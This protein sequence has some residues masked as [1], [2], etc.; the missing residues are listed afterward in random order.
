MS[1]RT[2]FRDS[3]VAAEYPDRPIRFIVPFAAGGPG[4]MLARILAER[5]TAIWGQPVEIVIRH[6]ANGIAGS[7]MTARAEADGYTIAISASAFY[8]N[9]SIYRELPFDSIADFAPVALVAGGPN[10]LVTHP[11]V[12]AR[13][14]SEFIAHARA[15]PGALAYASGGYGS[16]SHLAGELFN[17][18]AG[19]Q[20][21]HVPY[22]GHAA[23][24]AALSEGREVQ[25]MYDAVFTCIDHI[26]D[27]DWNALAVTTKTRAAQLP[28]VPTMDESGLWNFEI[29]P[30]MGVL[31]PAGTPPAIVAK[32]GAAIGAIV[33]EPEVAARIR[34]YG[35]EPIGSSPE[36][37]AAYVR[38]EI[39]KWA[40][41]V[42]NAGLTLLD[43]PE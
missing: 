27:G 22:K 5:F 14:L 18:M 13:N 33:R 24:G 39:G 31:A 40:G 37:Y 43:R 6:G 36:E 29:S 20:I 11:K 1:S 30:A 38:S 26:R 4:D 9:P 8:I 23:A 21:R 25:L 2:A 3:D 41:V 32:L 10:V 16:P 35:A 28:N 17:R 15:H 42:K 34:R 7:E 12:A 19:V